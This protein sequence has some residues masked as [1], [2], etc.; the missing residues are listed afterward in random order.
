MQRRTDLPALAAAVVVLAASA[1]PAAGPAVPRETHEQLVALIRSKT[2]RIDQEATAEGLAYRRGT[3]SQRFVPVDA[4]TPAR[5]PGVTSYQATY[6]KDAP[7]AEVLQ[8]DRFLL[9]LSQGAGGKWTIT[10]ERLEST[11][12]GL[13]RPTPGDE[14]FQRFARLNLD[15]EG[16]R[17][18][19]GA[20]TLV[21]DHLAGQPRRIVLAADDLEYEYAPPESQ[22]FHQREILQQDHAADFIFQ[23]H[24]VM[25]DCVPGS[26]EPFLQDDLEGLETIARADLGP[27]LTAHYERWLARESAERKADPFAGFERAPEPGHPHY[28]ISVERRD[29]HAIRLRY[30]TWAADEVQFSATGYGPL[31]AYPAAATLAGGVSAYDVERREDR[32]AQDYD[33]T[34]LRGDVELALTDDEVVTGD[35]EFRLR[36]KRPL[37]ELPF[38]FQDLTRSRGGPGD[39]RSPVITI[40]VLQDQATGRDLTWVRTGRSSG[41][42]VFPEDLAQDAEVVLRM[43]F[44]NR[45]SIL[46]F[47][48]SY[49]YMDRAGWLPFVRFDDAIEDFDLTVRAP[50]RYQVLGVG[51]KVADDTRD[52]VRI[53]RWVAGSPV[54][55]PTLIFG[56]Y[57]VDTP[58]TAAERF[59]GTP[60]PVTIHVDRHGMT[61]WG[62]R[63]KQLQPLAEQAVNALNIYRTLFGVD[64]P[65]GKLDLVNDYRFY[66]GQA[67]GSIIYLGNAA[68]RSS[69]T[70]SQAFRDP[71]QAF[72]LS[73][74]LVAHEVAHQWWGSAI[75]AANAK[76]YWFIESLAEYSAALFTEI[77]ESDGFRKPEQGR[78]AYLTQVERWR[79][80]VLNADPLASVARASTLWSDGGYRAALYAKGPYVFHMLRMTFGDEKF[81]EFLNRMGRQLAGQAVVGRDIQQL[82]EASL[83]GVDAQGDA[84]RVELEWFFDQWIRGIGIPEYTFQHSTRRTEDGKYIVE[85]RIDQRVLAGRKKRELAGVQFRAMVPITVLGS[86]KQDYGTTILVDGPQ[87]PFMFKVPVQPLEVRLNANGDVLAWDVIEPD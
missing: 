66:G 83:G 5:P 74:M 64:Y 80:E 46:Q 35:I 8:S 33:L 73:Q 78:K 25:I 86:D 18:S 67:P 17:I 41:L 30:D 34:G 38:S 54:R 57:V 75:G 45:G 81:F 71:R 62:I 11:Y 13:I 68:F 69:T 37:R 40:D 72:A 50:A 14:A 12:R 39:D 20:G 47:T 4:P 65:Y 24:L 21:V 27:A 3:Y 43:R 55:F 16:L 32:E 85:G 2:A 15:R 59:D 36:I 84:Y 79:G 23:P 61:D 56:D 44:E 49:S 76:S 58:R 26:C 52:K 63:P 19:A 53:T 87:T 60:I 6:I 29:E 42:V 9:T 31:Y 10:D 70:L 77:V 1:V 22:A 51:T 82:A 7:G 28:A 48:P